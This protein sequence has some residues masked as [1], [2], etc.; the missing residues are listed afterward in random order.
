MKQLHFK[1]MLRNL[2][3]NANF[4]AINIFGLS[5]S[6]A[7]C[8]L[9]GLY[10]HFETNFD[11]SNPAHPKMY[12]L[13]TT[14]KYPNSPESTH[15]LSSVMMGPYLHRECRDVEQY[16]RVVVGG[17]EKMLCRSGRREATLQ[18]SFEV[19]PSFFE[20]FK[21][22][23][24]EGDH[25]TALSKPGSIVLTR[26][27]SEALFGTEM[28][29]GKTLETQF[30]L[31]S[32]KDTSIFF[33][34]SGVLADL[35]HNSHLQFDALFPLDTR[36]YETW[37][38]G[39]RWHG[40]VANTYFRL[41]PSAQSGAA[42]EPVFAE[43]LKKEM[44][45]SE[46]IALHMQPFSDIHLGSTQ[47]EDAHNYLKSN[48]KY[49]GILGMI[50]LFILIISSVNFANLS[51]VLALK[52]GQEVGIRKSLGAS[53]GDILQYFLG[54]SSVMA[55]L[56]G[57]LGLFWAT[58]LRKPFLDMLGRDFELPFPTPVLAAFVGVVCL[59]GLSSGLYPALQAARHG[60][61]KAIKGQG[62]A[63]SVKRPFVQRLVVLQFAL[64]G[65]LIIGSLI[66]YHQ[67]S[68]LKNKDLGFQYA[69]VVELN[70]GA[71]NWMHSS[72]LKTELAALPGVV[73]VSGSDASLGTIDAQNGVMVRDPETRQ[74]ENFPM[75]II[76]ADYNYFDLYQMQFVAGRAPSREG[77]A[78]E[79]EYV[80][81]ESFIKKVGWKN[82]PI[83]Q[84][85]ARAG[86]GNPVPGRVV[87]II[88]DVHHNTLRHAIQ[89]ICIQASQYSSIISLKIAPANIQ[90]TLKQ[91]EAVWAQ[92]IKDRPFDFTFMD[93]HFAKVYD[94][95]NR[96]AQALFLATLL[97]IVIACLGLLALSAFIISRRTKE[98]GIRK[99]LGASV[100]SIVGIL[101]KDFLV[102]VAVSFAIASLP[103]WY[104]MK[105]WLNDFAYHID[106]AWWMF[107]ASGAAA[108]LI[109]FLTVGIQSVRSALAN[110]VV[111]LKNE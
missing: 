18:Q 77:A 41:H 17:S 52:R 27:V 38:P 45:N 102:L 31:P 29:L 109:A 2:L 22:P 7:V 25:R 53:R 74:W 33:Q 70:I 95:E 79:L 11:R 81:N 67:L 107:A 37:A 106:M 14:F 65:M 62:T 21:Y 64:S 5:A 73:A 19:D 69:Q 88:R 42:L 44:P 12:R 32:G 16:L 108:L 6:L 103:A 98:I 15:A 28:P 84:E 80:V 71:G 56:A 51:T 23:M 1:L 60:V 57:A 86:Y 97:S 8:L 46:M 85:I 87:G 96:L 10:L 48:Q 58:L 104:F 78:N 39:A 26:P 9:I 24:L 100:A 92:H 30:T 89:P 66:C 4:S 55:L 75:S 82:D 111:S 47:I 35:P 110:P 101:A 54:E 99:V 63:L 61:L 68:F 20:F 50:A 94:S 83:G 93:A 49:I 40:I 36:P 90:T 105:H 72:T 76:R 59:L 3:K 34:V 43:A 13:L 91:A